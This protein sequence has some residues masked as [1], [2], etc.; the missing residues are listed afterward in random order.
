MDLGECHATIGL[1]SAQEEHPLGGLGEA[2][3]D[4]TQVVV[5]HD[6]DGVGRFY[7][8]GIKQTR[9]MRSEREAALF[10][11]LEGAGIGE[12]AGPGGEAGARDLHRSSAASGLAGQRGGGKGTPNDV[13]VANH[14]EVAAPAHDFTPVAATGTERGIDD[15]VQKRPALL[16]IE[17]RQ[18]IAPAAQRGGNE[19]LELEG[20]E[21]G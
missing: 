19:A 6:E 13:A 11:G 8:S 17:A 9:T 12:F 1:A 5:V 15:R 21:A 4:A 3:E 14:D 2:R 16:A 7:L 10:A 18:H 20:H